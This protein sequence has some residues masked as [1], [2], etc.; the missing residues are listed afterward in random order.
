MRTWVALAALS[1]GVWLAGAAW[2]DGCFFGRSA[3]PV[4]PNQ[5]ALLYL[6]QGQETM[7]LQVR[8]Q[9]DGTEDF[10][11]VVPVPARPT[12]SE[13][14][15]DLFPELARYTRPRLARQQEWTLT[16][17]RSMGAV[18]QGGVRVV[19]ETQVGAYKITVLSADAPGALEK[20][21]Q[22]HQYHLPDHARPI[23]AE[24]I[25]K[26]WF[27]V[28][29]QIDPGAVAAPVLNQMRQAGYTITRLET[30]PEEL[31]EQVVRQAEMGSCQVHR[32]SQQ[33]SPHGTLGQGGSGRRRPT[34]SICATGR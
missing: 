10:G 1:V 11:W 27:F 12:F 26:K 14:S 8:Y 7:V 22:D 18:M 30:M 6:D 24:Y 31:A 28:A 20:W 13:A 2:A 23:L 34:W 32:F 25:R 33:T 5:A 17:G 9:G 19:E 16:K 3:P 29:T 21:L 15:K 4:E